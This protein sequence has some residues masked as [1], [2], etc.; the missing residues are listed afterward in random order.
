MWLFLEK[1]G[2]KQEKSQLNI[3]LPSP[4]FWPWTRVVGFFHTRP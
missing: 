4:L 2:D 3:D 1:F